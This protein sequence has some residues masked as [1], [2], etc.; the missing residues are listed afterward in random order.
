M[1]SFYRDHEGKDGIISFTR[2]LEQRSDNAVRFEQHD[3]DERLWRLEP[4][5]LEEI[6]TFSQSKELWPSITLNGPRTFWNAIRRSLTANPPRF[7][8]TLPGI[9]L[10]PSDTE[11]YQQGL[12]ETNLHERFAIGLWQAVDEH[13][14]RRGMMPFRHDAAFYLAIRGGAIARAWFDPDASQPFSVALW[15]PRTVVTEPGADGLDFAAHHYWTPWYDITGRYGKR[16]E[17]VQPDTN[18]NVEV[19]DCWWLEDGKV[20]NAVYTPTA[21]LVPVQLMSKIDHL[22]IVSVRAFGPDIEGAYE[23]QGNAQRRTLDAWESI[24]A[25]NRSTYAVLNRIATLYSLYL[26]RLAIGPYQGDPEHNPLPDEEIAKALGKPF[27]F[28]R[29]KVEPVGTP[30]MAAETKEFFA[31]AQGMEQRGAVPYSVYGQTPFELSGFAINQLQGAL[32]IT[33]WPLADALRALYRLMTD[34]CI[35]QFRARG[36]RKAVTIRGTDGRRQPFLEDIRRASLR[37]KY[38][39]EVELEPELPADKL[40][41]AQIAQAWASLGADPITVAD[42][43]LKVQDPRQ[44]VQRAVAWAILQSRIQQAGAGSANG[45]PPNVM[46]PGM[47]GMMPVTPGAGTGMAPPAP[48]VG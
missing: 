1:P 20:Y 10:D 28:F 11:A 31:F 16:K 36:S 14:L 30:Q 34:E 48:V 33:V 23:Q 17:D 41:E 32:S 9:Q 26:R 19:F 39:L 45:M 35:Q 2:S 24:Y 42:E 12:A 15:D 46:P 3:R 21:E 4:Y 29:G 27:Q 5:T 18:G 37:D 6:G 25:A 40:Q 13:R 22:P 38:F 43:F 7:R 44:F 8:I 47:Q